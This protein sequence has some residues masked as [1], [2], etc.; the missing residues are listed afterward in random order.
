MKNKLSL[1]LEALA[2]E[3][4]V[5]DEPPQ[6]R[7]TVF[8]RETNYPEDSCGQSCESYCICTY[9]SQCVCYPDTGGGGGTDPT[10]WYSCNQTVYTCGNQPPYC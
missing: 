4:F 5:P 2:V 3:S 8:G 6:E 7:G 9:E 10:W 1:D